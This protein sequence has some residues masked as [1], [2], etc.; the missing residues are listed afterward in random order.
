AVISLIFKIA[1]Y[2]YGPLLGLFSFGLFTR[3][4]VRDRWVL[5]VCLLAPL[6]TWAIE[7]SSKQWLDV[8]FLTILINGVLTF[9]GLW[10][11]SYRD[12]AEQG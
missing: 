4:K 11:I 5:Y 9:L 7:M 12:D 8:G 1:G 10:A 2:T 6:L 3:L